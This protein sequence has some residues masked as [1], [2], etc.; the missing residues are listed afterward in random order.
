MSIINVIEMKDGMQRGSWNIHVLLVIYLDLLHMSTNLDATKSTLIVYNISLFVKNVVCTLFTKTCALVLH[1][2]RKFCRF[3]SFLQWKMPTGNSFWPKLAKYPA[4]IFHFSAW[5]I[6]LGAILIRNPLELSLIKGSFIANGQLW[7]PNLYLNP[8]YIFY[9]FCE[10]DM[11]PRPCILSI[12]EL[13]YVNALLLVENYFLK[14]LLFQ[15]KM[16]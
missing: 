1:L 10:L 5:F 4:V 6:G 11:G 3:F 7:G 13:N 9:D 14:M 16:L 12:T 8:T 2:K 15:S